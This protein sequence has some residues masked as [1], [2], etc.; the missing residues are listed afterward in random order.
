MRTFVREF[1]EMK[2]LIFAGF[3]LAFC[4]N[5]EANFSQNFDR[6]ISLKNDFEIYKLNLKN[7]FEFFKERREFFLENESVQFSKQ[8]FCSIFPILNSLEKRL[9]IALKNFSEQKI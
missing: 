1:R 4:N 7:H 8:N 5:V 2:K 3:F 6:E 9:K